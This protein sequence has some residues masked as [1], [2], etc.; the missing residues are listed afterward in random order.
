MSIHFL[1]LIAYNFPIERIENNELLN[2]SK[3]GSSFD[4]AITNLKLKNGGRAK[5]YA[6]YCGPYNFEG[7]LLFENGILK[8]DPNK[9]GPTIKLKF[10]PMS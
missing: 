1:D 5:I 6:S 2:L 4:T 7:S 3:I 8:F 9:I 10:P